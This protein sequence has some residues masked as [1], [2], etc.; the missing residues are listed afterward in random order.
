[1]LVLT[2]IALVGLGLLAVS[3]TARR[4]SVVP[5]LLS[6]PLAPQ[7]APVPARESDLYARGGGPP[8]LLL[9]R[10]PELRGLPAEGLADYVRVVRQFFLAGNLPTEAWW[11]SFVQAQSEILLRNVQRTGRTSDLTDP[12]VE[13]LFAWLI[14]LEERGMPLNTAERALLLNVREDATYRRA[15]PEAQ[16]PGPDATSA[17]REA[18]LAAN[19]ELRAQIATME[20]TVQGLDGNESSYMAEADAADAE[21]RAQS[22]ADVEEGAARARRWGV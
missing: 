19:A 14:T 11:T 17:E 18:I 10:E 5:P 6:R 3:G 7:R 21:L 1:M 12:Q 16:R 15:H 9:R 4:G 20:A 22:E 13:A 8:G 2:V